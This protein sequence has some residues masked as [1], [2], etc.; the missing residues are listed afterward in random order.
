MA[1]SAISKA[2][3]YPTLV[4]RDIS[5]W[6]V[7]EKDSESSQTG[8]RSDC[9]LYFDNDRTREV[10]DMDPA[11]FMKKSKMSNEGK[12][13]RKE[14]VGRRAWGDMVALIEAKIDHSHSAFEFKKPGSRF[15]REKTEGGRE[16]LGQLAEYIAHIFAHQHR[17]HVYAMYVYRDQARICFFDRSG[18]VVSTPFRYGKPDDHAFQ[19]FFYRLARMSREQLG[20]DPTATLADES[21]VK[22]LRAF[23]GTIDSDYHRLLAYKALCWDPTAK[24]SSS[25]EWP[26][27]EIT[28]NG[29]TL[30]VGKP[31]FSNLSLFGRCTRGYAAI[32]RETDENGKTIYS[33]RFL[34]DSWRSVHGKI[35]AEHE[36]YERL[37]SRGVL[38]NIPTCLGGE[39]VRG[40]DG[41]WQQTR[42]GARLPSESLPRGHY[43]ILLQE[44][45]RPLSDF[46][47]FEELAM[48]IGDAL[49]GTCFVKHA[50]YSFVSDAILSAS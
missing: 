2:R 34:K 27:H 10:I 7:S 14:W 20:Y 33:L 32:E 4:A 30:F 24:S 3:E 41:M 31:A 28:L 22:E 29:K 40:A 49:S 25:V 36:V 5:C 23:A 48:L 46:T 19:R 6:Q 45:C 13:V 17:T 44:V 15:T 11:K 37:R 16:A 50:L 47:N 21:V 8:T 43:R 38:N 18:G 9:A 26:V 12:D 35:H 39:D 1:K 42:V